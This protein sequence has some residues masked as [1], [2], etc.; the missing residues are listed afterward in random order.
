[1]SFSCYI[2][3]GGNAREAMTEY[4]EIFG[5]TDLDI[6]SFADFPPDQRPPGTDDLVMHAQFSAGPGAPL[7]G[8]DIPPGMGTPGMGGTSIFH[9]APDVAT[10][11]RIFAA[12]AKGGAVEMP[13]AAT[14]WSPAFGMVNDR[15][16]HRWMISVPPAAPDA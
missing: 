4:A 5:A 14:F 16:G 1:M 7:M 3:F 13:L 6:R 10:A 15:F 2:G 11:T 12:L 9:G 8:C